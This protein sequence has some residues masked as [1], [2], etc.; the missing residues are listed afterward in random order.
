MEKKNKNFYH[1][2]YQRSLIEKVIQ[3][4]FKT[5][6][7]LSDFINSQEESKMK[8]RGKDYVVYKEKLISKIIF[9]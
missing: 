3:T 6:K 5:I 2:K 9:R 4:E 1:V 7:N 8:S